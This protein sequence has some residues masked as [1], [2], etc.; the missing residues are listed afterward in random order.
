MITENDSVSKK[1]NWE[2]KIIEMVNS[3][4]INGKVRL[5][6]EGTDHF[7]TFKYDKIKRKEFFENLKKELAKAVPVDL[8][9]ID[10]SEKHEIDT[11][12][13]PEQPEQYILSIN[14]KKSDIDERSADLVAKDLDTL[15]KNK[16]VTVIGSGAYSNYLD[17][18][19]GYEP[20][21]K[22]LI[23]FFECSFE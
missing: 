12:I 13:P 17:H 10:T 3:T 20:I 23:I 6:V 7:K 1:P 5:T 19:Y 22:N 14:I 8:E 4:R 21:R 9:R 15:I 2:K 16:L 11:S 18:K